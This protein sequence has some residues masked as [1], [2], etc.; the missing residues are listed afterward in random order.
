MEAF[1][2]LKKVALIS[3]MES[4]YEN[5]ILAK[6]T[7]LS[8]SGAFLSSEGEDSSISSRNMGATGHVV[9]RIVQ[10]MAVTFPQ[11]SG[12]PTRVTQSQ[13]LQRKR[14]KRY[15]K[16]RRICLFSAVEKRRGNTSGPACQKEND[17]KMSGKGKDSI[18]W[19]V[20]FARGMLLTS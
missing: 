11:D 17:F 3:S 20:H 12:L 9:S 5:G 1:H 15:P 7:P 14:H 13:R 10:S 2:C 4:F 8:S 16:K 18:P 19:H 6:L